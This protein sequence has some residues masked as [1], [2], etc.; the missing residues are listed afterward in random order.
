M[1]C[2]ILSSFLI[3]LSSQ[4]TFAA[5]PDYMNGLANPHVQRNITA[6]VNQK[7]GP[8]RGE[9]YPKEVKDAYR[10][11]EFRAKMEVLKERFPAIYAGIKQEMDSKKAH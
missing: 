2:K 11:C 4:A 6:Y 8:E 9:E 1:R 7:C 3:I 5:T 10:L